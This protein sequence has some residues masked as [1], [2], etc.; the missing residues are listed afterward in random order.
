MHV[1]E[2]NGEVWSRQW[3][4]EIRRTPST[5]K[6]HIKKSNDDYWIHFGLKFDDFAIGKLM[7]NLLED[8]ACSK[9][10]VQLHLL[11]SL[12]S[13]DHPELPF[14]DLAT[15]INI[16]VRAPEEQGE[17]QRTYKI[18]TLENSSHLVVSKVTGLQNCYCC[19]SRVKSS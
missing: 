16:S 17:S 2:R 10:V 14:R 19:K 3:L 18:V 11:S 8:V 4:K 5:G 7:F 6:K 13:S 15:D 1:I 9:R 12:H